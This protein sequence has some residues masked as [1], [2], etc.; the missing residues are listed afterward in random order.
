MLSMPNAYSVDSGP[1]T[2]GASPQA[3]QTYDSTSRIEFKFD[4]SDPDGCC[5]IV[6][7]FCTRQMGPKFY[8]F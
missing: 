6:S 3:N 7:V 5:N 8:R 2:F 1:T 4:V